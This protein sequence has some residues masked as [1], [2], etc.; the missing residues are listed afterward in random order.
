MT[1][2]FVR[3]L[4]QLLPHYSKFKTL[5]SLFVLATCFILPIG[6]SSVEASQEKDKINLKVSNKPLGEVSTLISTQT[7]YQIILD[8]SFSPLLVS[9]D[10]SNISAE[11]FF[12]RVLKDKNI[13]MKFDPD[14]NSLTVISFGNSSDRDKLDIFNSSPRNKE[15]DPQNITL[16]ELNALHKSQLADTP[17]ETK[18]S[19]IAGTNMTIGEL[20]EMQLKQQKYNAQHLPK[21]EIIL[22]TNM[23]ASELDALQEKQNKLTAANDQNDS[24]ILGT[25]LTL[26]QL[27]K[28]QVIQSQSYS[29][30]NNTQE[31]ILGTDMTITELNALHE[32]QSRHSPKPSIND[33]IH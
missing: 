30:E 31:T 22:G 18:D 26:A 17:I 28:A 16:A 9:G 29:S 33:P 3:N 4:L 11:Q 32:Y 12:S 27:N 20:D 5:F 8:Q 19:L 14:D 7:G 6:Q 2:N 10:F 23:T 25:E 13:V 1:I 15:I 24:K 21:D